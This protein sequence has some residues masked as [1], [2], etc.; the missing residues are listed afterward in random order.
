MVFYFYVKNQ[1]VLV[2]QKLCLNH[3]EIVTTDYF[4]HKKM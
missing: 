3:L 4:L 2:C 1:K